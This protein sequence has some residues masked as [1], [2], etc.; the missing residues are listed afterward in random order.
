LD[1]L[2]ANSQSPPGVPASLDPIT[3]SNPTTSSSAELST[4]NNEGATTITT[5]VDTLNMAISTTLSTTV[6]ATNTA[7]ASTATAPDPVVLSLKNTGLSQACRLI[8]DAAAVFVKEEY[9]FNLSTYDLIL[10]EQDFYLASAALL[11]KVNFCCHFIFLHECE[12]VYI[13]IASSAIYGVSIVNGLILYIDCVLFF[14]FFF[15]TRAA[16][17]DVDQQECER[18]SSKFLH[19]LS[20]LSPSLRQGQV[21][22]MSASTSNA[23]NG[24]SGTPSK[25]TSKSY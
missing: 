10:S 23:K 8:D 20:D 24:S 15:Q 16:F 21:L 5:T 19:Q 13:C 18:K 6:E 9:L 14:S 11:E 2:E 12:S 7:A 1:I 22:T 4:N 17:G 25:F 3:L